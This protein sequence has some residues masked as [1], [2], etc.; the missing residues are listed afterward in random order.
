[1]VL[2]DKSF[3]YFIQEPPSIDDYLQKYICENWV[4]LNDSPAIAAIATIYTLIAQLSCGQVCID[5]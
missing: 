1:M 2:G 4:L 5:L 3:G